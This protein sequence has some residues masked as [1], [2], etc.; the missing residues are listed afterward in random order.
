MGSC[1]SGSRDYEALYSQ[2]HNLR[3]SASLLIKFNLR[4]KHLSSYFVI[5]PILKCGCEECSSLLNDVGFVGEFD[6]CHQ[7][8]LT[9]FSILVYQ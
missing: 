1:G 6:I 4:N 9:S 8:A 3:Q 7:F 5:H 2:R